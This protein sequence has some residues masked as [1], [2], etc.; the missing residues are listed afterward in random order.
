M[1]TKQ[2][3]RIAAWLKETDIV[4]FTYKKD[5]ADIEIKTADAAAQASEFDCNLIPVT[6]PAVGVYRAAEKGESN[7]LKEGMQVEE[8]AA[9]GIIETASKKVEVKSPA[10][11]ILRVISI[12][13]AKPVEYGQ[14]LFF[15]E[16]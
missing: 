3:T 15:I 6:S 10:K 12:E 13:E 4:D 16:A 8:G 14:P 11:G 9:L 7:N 2:L 1:D 5:G